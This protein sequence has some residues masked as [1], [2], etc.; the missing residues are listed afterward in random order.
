MDEMLKMYLDKINQNITDLRNDHNIQIEHINFNIDNKVN[1]LKK[2]MEN[3]QLKIEEIQKDYVNNEDFKKMVTKEYCNNNKILI[4]K[5]IESDVIESNVI[6]GNLQ[7][8]KEELSIKKIVLITSCISGI[9]AIIINFF[10]DI[11]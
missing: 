2:I 9:V 10:K 8:K 7:I 3:L 6:D 4:E 11:L 1:D 5:K